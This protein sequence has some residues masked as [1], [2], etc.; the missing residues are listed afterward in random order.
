MS[1]RSQI[2]GKV[3]LR[4]EINGMPDG[5][6]PGPKLRVELFE[7]AKPDLAWISELNVLGDLP[8][9]EGEERKVE[10]RIMS[11]EFRDYVTTKRPNLSVRHG[12]QV[13]G[14]LKLE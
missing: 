14:S 10:I 13:I 11:D 1:D 3:K 4:P 12:S 5:G 9:H 7:D 2:I 8:W 6:L